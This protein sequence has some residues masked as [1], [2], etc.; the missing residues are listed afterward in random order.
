MT[1][2]LTMFAPLAA[3]VFFAT[4][5]A[6]QAGGDVAAGQATAAACAACHGPNGNSANAAFP[7]LAGQHAGYIVKQLNE[8]K[9]GTRVNGIMAGMVA[10][11]SA[12]DMDNIA[13]YYAAQSKTPLPAEGQDVALIAQGRKLYQSGRP[14]AGV[15]ACAACHGANGFGN[16][17]AG[18]PALHAQHALYIDGALK[19]FRDGS[20]ANDANSLMR[21][22]AAGLTDDDI[23][24]LAA[25][26]ASLH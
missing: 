5:P 2:R 6:V 15:A 1:T 7:S 26:S 14:E 22:A 9:A 11:L 23:R 10:S 4:T 25:Y 3:A 16:P 8:Y 21:K 13:A 20:R 24:A 17:G 19:A 18:Y 12:E